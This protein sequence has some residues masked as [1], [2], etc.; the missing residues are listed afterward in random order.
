MQSPIVQSQLHARSTG[1]TVLGFKQSELR[2]V[3][4]PL[5]SKE[6]QQKIASVLSAY[7]NL[8]ENNIA[9]LQMYEQILQ[10]I[11]REWFVLLRFPGNKK[12]KKVRYGQE[13]IPEGWDIKPIELI[14]EL[15]RGKSYTSDDLSGDNAVPFFNLKNIQRNGGF[16]NDG[17]KVYSGKFKEEHTART[18]DILVAVTDMTQERNVIAR[19]ARVPKLESNFGVFSMDL[20]KL[21]PRNGISKSWLYG[22]LRYSQFPDRVK[23]YA[24]GANVLH[25]LPDRIKEYRVIV[26]PYDLQKQFENI[27]DPIYLL[28]DSLVKKNDYLKEMRDLLLPK[29]ISGEID[30]SELDIEKLG[31][32]NGA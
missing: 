30:I 13:S 17:T 5:H 12:H 8:Y 19:A 16:R 15:Y 20:I 27:V 6:I 9:R 31:G 26:P 28:S 1:T 18:G 2:Q 10:L 23:E 24:N 21:E 4:V 3:K 22:L 32:T 11:F 25:L 7:D 14:A 29:L